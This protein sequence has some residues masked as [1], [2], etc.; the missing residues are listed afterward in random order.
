MK[1]HLT[2]MQKKILE[3][4][5][6]DR[7]WH[8]RKEMHQHTGRTK[9]YSAAMG[10]PNENNIPLHSLEGRG[11]VEHRNATRQRKLEYRITNDGLRYV[12]NPNKQIDTEKNATDS[13][14]ALMEGALRRVMSEE[15]ERNRKARQKCIALHGTSCAVCE[16]SFEG[17]YGDIG[18]DFIHVHHRTPISSHS[19]ER[20]VDPFN[21]LIPVC[22]NCHAMLHKEDP[23]MDPERL[24]LRMREQRSK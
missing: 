7:D 12:D 22:P 8:T 9:G 11:L 19:K 15:R 2:E 16:F 13:G 14:V 20:E 21:D 18:R 24:R 6:I 3:F 17:T 10:A 1:T 5:A 23:P 4:L